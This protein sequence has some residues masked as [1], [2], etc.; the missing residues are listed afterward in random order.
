MYEAVAKMT[1]PRVIKSHFPG[2]ILPPDIMRKKARVVYVA[3]N[4]KDVAVSYYYFH[5]SNPAMS[6]YSSWNEF[7]DDYYSGKGEFNTGAKHR[8]LLGREAAVT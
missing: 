4:P 6:A 5:N 8:I 3:R 1:S 2:Q 7:F